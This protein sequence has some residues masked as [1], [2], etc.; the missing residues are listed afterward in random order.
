MS[1]VLYKPI[2]IL[3]WQDHCSKV[4]N[5]VLCRADKTTCCDSRCRR[6]SKSNLFAHAEQWLCCNAGQIEAV[7]MLDCRLDRCCWCSSLLLLWWRPRSSLP[8]MPSATEAPRSD[9][10]CSAIE[11]PRFDN[12]AFK[13]PG[14]PTSPHPL[15]SHR[16]SKTGGKQTVDLLSHTV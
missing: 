2:S 14:A 9:N 7:D 15:R 6:S 8:T 5:Y 12:R 11:A 3:I 13:V 1:D 10:R 16:I 4:S